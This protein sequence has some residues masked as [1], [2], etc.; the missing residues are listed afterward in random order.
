MRSS[1]E[2]QNFILKIKK[3]KNKIIINEVIKQNNN[4]R[5]KKNIN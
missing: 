1:N 5:G 3:D 4:K 2:K